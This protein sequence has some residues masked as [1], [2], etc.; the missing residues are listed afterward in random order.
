MKCLFFGCE[1]DASI[2]VYCDNCFTT[3]VIPARKRLIEKGPNYMPHGRKSN[4]DHLY[5]ERERPYSDACTDFEQVKRR[6]Y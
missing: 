3:K 5:G 2:D 6:L 1:R 4:F